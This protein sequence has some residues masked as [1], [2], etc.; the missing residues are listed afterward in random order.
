MFKMVSLCLSISKAAISALEKWHG[1][2]I[3][4][5]NK[6]KETLKERDSITDCM[7]KCSKIE[8]QMDRLEQIVRCNGN[9]L[10]ECIRNQEQMFAGQCNLT[11][12][13]MTVPPVGE[14]QQK[15]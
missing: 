2:L 10:D 1:T 9:A 12:K 6:C 5:C 13:L 7:P 3:W 11:E 15:S 14:L 4:L 8:T